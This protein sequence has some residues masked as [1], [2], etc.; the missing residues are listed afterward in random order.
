MIQMMFMITA[1][2]PPGGSRSRISRPNGANASTASLKHWMPKG[3]PIMV[4]HSR[5]APSV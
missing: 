3:M 1:S 4:R 2:A 5:I